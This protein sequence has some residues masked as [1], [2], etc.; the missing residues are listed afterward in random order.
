MT[1]EHPTIFYVSSTVFIC[2]K[3][4]ISKY[5]FLKHSL[6][7]KFLK[8]LQN[9]YTMAYFSTLNESVFYLIVH[10]LDSF[11][12]SFKIMGST[13]P[14]LQNQTPFPPQTLRGPKQTLCPPGPRDPTETET[15][16]FECLLWRYGSAVD[17]HRGSSVGAAHFGMVGCSRLQYGITPLGGGHH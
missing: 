4:Q 6:I 14:H 13:I 2:A 15:K 1:L 11:K 12:N 3:Y 8:E 9:N 16:L 7:K 5:L 10:L 17:C